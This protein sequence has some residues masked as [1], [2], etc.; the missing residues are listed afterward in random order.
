MLLNII[1]L[2]VVLNREAELNH[3]VNAAREGRRLVEREA[4]GEQRRLEEEVDEVL[5]RLVALVG[6]GLRLE[7]LHDRVLRVDLHRLLRR[8]VGGHRVVA[9]GLGAHDALHVGGPAVLAR[10]QDARRL[11]DALGHHHLLDLIAE[12]LLHEL[13]ERLEVGAE[14]LPRLLLLLRLLKLEALLRDGDELPAVVLLE[15]LDAVL[16]NRVD[17]EEDL[18]VAL[19]ALLDEGRRLN[20]LLRLAGDVVDVLLRL[21]HARDVVLERGLLVARLGRVEHEQLREL[22][23]VARVLVDAELDVL[24]KLLV[25]LLEVLRVLLDLAKELD[26]LL[27]DV[28]LDHLEDLVLLQRLARDVER[29]VLRV[30]DALDEGEPL[31]DEV[32]AVVH[33]EDAADV[34][35]DV[36]RVLLLRLEEIKRRALRHEKDRGELELALH[37]EVLDRQV[38]LP[39]IRERLVEGAVLLLRHLLRLAHPDRLLLV[40]QVPLVRHL[41]HLLLLLLLLRLVLLDLLDLGL[42]A[43]L[44]LLV[45]VVVVVVVVVDLLVDGLLGPQ[46]DRVVDELR[47]LLHQVLEAALLEVLELVLLEVARDLRA[48]PERLAV[49]VLPHGERAAGRRLPD[50]L[51]VLVVLRRDDH[52]VGDEV[53]RVEADAELADHVDVGARLHRLHE[54][55]GAR[56]RDGAEVGDHLGLRHADARVDDRQRVVRLVRHQADEELGVRVEHRLVGERLVADLVERVRRVRDELAQE[57]LLVRVEGVDDER[58]QL[59]DLRLEGE[60]LDL[61]GHGCW[62]WF[63]WGTSGDER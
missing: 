9:E 38:L 43:V 39:I 19:L 15:L 47:V 49:G 8:H 33:D 18:V 58:H 11:G 25:E 44:A 20:R 62:G 55:L 27:H 45:V 24:A 32:L 37:G 59:V 50:V 14:L 23:A 54:R 16:V 5:D 13:R 51:L 28:L 35:L 1:R 46:R 30:D 57:D 31:G 12:N 34:Q 17:H 7:L 48:A 10:N 53:R 29:Q 4:R 2:V 6:G 36:A 26:A 52:A 63:F 61:L 42:V 40:H 41:L 60:R 21:G 3:A 22:R 56:L